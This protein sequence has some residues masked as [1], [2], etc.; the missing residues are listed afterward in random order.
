MS[1]G[2]RK[3]EVSGQAPVVMPGRDG[4][5]YLG[6]AES[7]VRE[8]YR[9]MNEPE[10]PTDT[11]TAD[12]FVLL[13]KSAK[14]KQPHNGRI[15]KHAS[16]KRRVVKLYLELEK[17]YMDEDEVINAVGKNEQINISE[18]KNSNDMGYEVKV[19]DQTDDIETK[20]GQQLMYN[21]ILQYAGQKLDPDQL[22]MII[23]LMPYA[24]GEE[25]TSDL[26]IN[27]DSARNDM[28]ALER[29]ERPPVNQYDDH[30]YMIKK[31]TKRMREPSFR[32]LHPSIQ[33][34]YALKIGIHQEFDA[35]NKK[36]LK[37]MENQF[38]P[39]SGPMVVC[40]V[41][42]PKP[43]KPAQTERV[44]LPSDAI[45]DLINKL[46]LQGTMVE[47]MEG[48]PEGAQAEVARKMVAS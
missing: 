2:I 46:K 33:Q 36:M 7:N 32:F 8:L 22:G 19:S 44:K 3:V 29:G 40:D 27:Y 43:G 26:T 37:M 13:F 45:Q 38:I 23:R 16:F 47:S 9:V 48:T 4:A 28:L 20:L 41:W 25:A 30:G 21:Q 42:V 11:G 39:T 1:P 24:N 17:L 6:V 12:P 14:Q 34:N 15:R 10:D 35:Y 5:Q 31:L 18:F